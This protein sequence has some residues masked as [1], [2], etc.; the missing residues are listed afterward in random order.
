MQ[1]NFST[2]HINTVYFSLIQKDEVISVVANSVIGVALLVLCML[3]L[4]IKERNRRTS[5]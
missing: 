1:D 5:K 3:G 4:L 2:D